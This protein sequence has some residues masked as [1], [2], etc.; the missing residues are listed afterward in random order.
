MWFWHPSTVLFL[1]LK[2]WSSKVGGKVSSAK[3]PESVRKRSKIINRYW[4]VNTHKKCPP[5]HFCTTRNLLGLLFISLLSI[6]SLRKEK[7]F[8]IKKKI[9]LWQM[10][11][12]VLFQCQDYP[13]GCYRLWRASRRLESSSR[14]LPSGTREPRGWGFSGFQQQLKI[15]TIML[16]SSI[17]TID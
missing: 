7:Y 14:Y 10:A 8:S 5:P 1:E 15:Q 4:I 3:G 17:F 16:L 2:L 6:W 12:D 9:H 11:A 13:Q